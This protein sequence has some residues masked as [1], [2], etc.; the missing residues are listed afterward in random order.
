M[1]RAAERTIKATRHAER[2]D[3]ADAVLVAALRTACERVDQRR[4][5]P[6]RACA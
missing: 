3:E 4:A 2:L 5:I 6:T 1:R